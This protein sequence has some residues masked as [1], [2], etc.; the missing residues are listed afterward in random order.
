MARCQGKHVGCYATEEVAARAYIEFMEDGIDHVKHRGVSTSQFKGFSWDKK[1]SK[2]K[3][4]CNGTYLGLQATEV[5]AARVCNKYLKDGVAPGPAGSSQ[6]K[7]VTWDKN[8][9]KWLA[10]CKGKHL[11]YHA[12]EKAAAQA[13]NV[14]AERVGRP[15]NVPR[16]PEP[17]A[18]VR[19]Q[20]VW[21]P[22]RAWARAREVALD[23]SVS[24]PR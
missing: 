13:Y 6:F 22:A 24:H 1:A 16:P 10:R 17:R 15:L 19:D 5:A 23:P 7:G 8:N 2:W 14:E 18:P 20:S 3:G 11:G 9:N 21:W 4:T 12:T